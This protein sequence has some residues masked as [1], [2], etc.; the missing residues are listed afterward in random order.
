MINILAVDANC[1]S[2]FTPEALQ[3]IREILGY[4]RILGPIALIIFIALDYGTAVIAQDNDALKKANSKVVSR[5]IAVALLFFVPLII[6]VILDLTPFAGKSSD[7]LCND[8]TGDKAGDV[9]IARM[10]K[11][12]KK[13]TNGSGT[14]NTNNENS[15]NPNKYNGN[16]NNNNNGA[17]QTIGDKANPKNEVCLENQPGLRDK[18]QSE[19]QA[20]I[21]AAGKDSRAAVVAT[22][23][24]MSSEIGIK[25]PYFP[26]GCHSMACLNKGIPKNIGCQN[27]VVHNASKWPPTLP[28]G[29]DCAGFTF[30]VYGAVFQQRAYI[31]SEMHN[32][33]SKSTDVIEASTGRKIGVSVEPVSIT[34][35]NY[36]YIKALLMPGDLVG[37][38]GHIGMVID[39]SRLQSQGVYT[40]AHAS[41]RYMQLSVEEFKLGDSKWNRFV[42][43]RK[44][45]LKYDCVNKND[46]SACQKFDCVADKNCNSNNIRY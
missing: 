34:K 43:M 46:Q 8:A 44:F 30:W 15:E 1:D 45:F 25:I 35:N 29:F 40:V 18:Y 22:A 12:E 5:S 36:D 6:T 28:S 23:I 10:P 4:F 9:F 19:L 33:G 3:I 14:I 32:A 16:G 11:V 24:Y 42:L 13:N 41:S 21:N 17:N 20:K 31:S 38:D 2:L 37:S 7:Y 39:T 26:G 27:T